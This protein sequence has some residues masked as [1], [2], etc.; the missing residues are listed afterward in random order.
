M[1]VMTQPVE[2]KLMQLDS[3]QRLNMGRLLKNP[4]VECVKVTGLGNGRYVIDTVSSVSTQ[5]EDSLKSDPVLLEKIE[6][7][8]SKKEQHLNAVPD[9]I[10]ALV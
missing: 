5:Y 8:K 6:E 1:V 7:D 4:A 9:D 10:L 2:T 3:R